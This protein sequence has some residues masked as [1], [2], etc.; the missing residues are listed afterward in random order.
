MSTLEIPEISSAFQTKIVFVI[1]YER[2]KVRDDYHWIEKWRVNSFVYRQG[3]V[4]VEL[5]DLEN[6]ASYGASERSALK[7]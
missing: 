4:A 6:H 5:D 2:A 7:A 3:Y 1:L